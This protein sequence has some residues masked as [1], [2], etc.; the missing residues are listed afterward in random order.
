[1]N[2]RMI[3]CEDFEGNKFK[4]WRSKVAV[5]CDT[6]EEAKRINDF[7]NDAVTRLSSVQAELDAE[8]RKL[9]ASSDET[10]NN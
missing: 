4:F 2:A 1:M 9:V 7:N 5:V 3:E 10:S 6:V 8:W